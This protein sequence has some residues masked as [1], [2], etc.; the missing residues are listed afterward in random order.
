MSIDGKVALI[1]GA[2]SGSDGRPHHRRDLALPGCQRGDDLVVHAPQI[3]QQL[4]VWCPRRP[5]RVNRRARSAAMVM[6]PL[7]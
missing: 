2:A 3:A 4:R 1:T 6:M 7:S 5:S